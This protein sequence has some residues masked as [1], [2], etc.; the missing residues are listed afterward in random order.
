M[1]SSTSARIF[2]YRQYAKHIDPLTRELAI[3][4]TVHNPSE[5]EVDEILLAE[6]D[7]RPGLRVLD[8]DDSQLALLPNEIARMLLAQQ[9]S[10]E[11]KDMLDRMRK[12]EVYLYWI[13]LPAGHELRA[14]ETRILRLTYVDGR[15]HDFHWW[16]P[17]KMFFNIPE[18]EAEFN[19][20][21]TVD[22][23]HFFCV[24]PP[25]GHEVRLEE[26]RAEAV[27]KQH[28]RALT[29]ADHYYLDSK[30]PII[31]VAIPHL[32]NET[33]S[34]RLVYGIYP[35]PNELYVLVGII[36]G[37]LAAS[38][39]FLAAL[40]I[41]WGDPSAYGTG[42]VWTLT[43]VKGL[44]SN[45]LLIGTSIVLT[46]AGFIGLSSGSVFQRSKWWASAS[47]VLAT[48]ALFVALAMGG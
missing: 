4:I 22:H 7:Y 35:E 1:T 45:A 30:G 11:A 43:A 9:T 25:E 10:P 6:E 27:S 39:V 36:L 3:E 34:V 26:I 40:L 31:D 32:K 8:F 21:S 29:A 37:L 47:A 18:Y 42:T 24:A 23:P 13:K 16:P 2:R 12:H 38:A 44:Q 41:L 5:D 17:P 20:V 15:H 33:A 14:H 46:S 48:L 28:R 19:V